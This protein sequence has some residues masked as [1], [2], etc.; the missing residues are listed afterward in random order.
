MTNE[1]IFLVEESEVGG[2]IARS[3][4]HSIYTE[5]D[6]FEELKHVVA[7]AIR[8]HFEESDTPRIVRFHIVKN[9]LISRL[10]LK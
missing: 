9:E 4:G 5:A 10:G 1:I 2:Y 6:T 3:L 8:C 7:D